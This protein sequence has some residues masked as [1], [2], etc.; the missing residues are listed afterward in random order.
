MKLMI[1]QR[2]AA[3]T[4]GSALLVALL[5]CWLST[6]ALQLAVGANTQ[7]AFAGR[8]RSDSASC[9][10][11]SQLAAATRLSAASLRQRNPSGTY[12][13]R[14]IRWSNRGTVNVS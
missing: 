8:E 14:S 6:A 2:L 11:R 5:L 13:S 3:A 9:T 10:H 1:V 7:L 4:C 12:T